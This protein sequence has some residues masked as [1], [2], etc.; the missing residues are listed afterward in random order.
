M[1]TKVIAA[2][3]M[4]VGGADGGKHWTRAE[5][6]A[7]Q[8]AADGMK[9]KRVVMRMPDWLGEEARVVW[10]RVLR[11]TKGLELLDNLDV[12]LLAGYCDAVVKYRQASGRLAHAGEV[13]SLANDD[14]VKACQAWARLVAMH[15]DKLG[16]TPAARARLVK[17]KADELIDEFGETFD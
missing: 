13:G 4:S 3:K 15:A 8:K 2:G 14:D 12:D 9:R 1:P 7:R 16:F 11:Q 6:A 5:V 10:R 17:Q